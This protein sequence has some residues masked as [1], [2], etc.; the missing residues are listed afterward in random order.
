LAEAVT[1]AFVLAAAAT[2]RRPT[3]RAVVCGHGDGHPLVGE[4]PHQRLVLRR[5]DLCCVHRFAHLR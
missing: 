1:V 2:R 5:S 3:G 4:Q